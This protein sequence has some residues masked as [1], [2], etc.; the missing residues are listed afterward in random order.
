MKNYLKDPN[1]NQSAFYKLSKT[2]LNDDRIM[3]DKRGEHNAVI[4]YMGIEDKI[5]LSEHKHK[6]ENDCS[7][8]ANGKYFCVFPVKTAAEELRIKKGKYNQHKA[9]LKE[10]GLIHFEEQEE[11]KSGF[12]SRIF[13]TP[14]E[15]WV[16][17]NGLYSFGEWIV[18]PASENFYNPAHIVTV[19]PNIRKASEPEIVEEPQPITEE[20]ITEFKD[21]MDKTKSLA[22]KFSKDNRADEVKGIVKKHLGKRKFLDATVHDLPVMR[23]VY[24]ELEEAY[25]YENLP[26]F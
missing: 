22:S 26:D 25:K 10:A 6:K 2:M 12:A 3:E 20:E 11:K 21:L 8:V 1:F 5:G 19:Q 7:F 4:L 24:D 16:E 17:Q 15:Q 18:E 23:K 13:I 9:L 14:W